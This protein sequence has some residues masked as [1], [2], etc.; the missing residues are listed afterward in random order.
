[1]THIHIPQ[2]EVICCYSIKVIILKRKIYFLVKKYWTQKNKC[3]KNIRY[4][5]SNW[6]ISITLSIKDDQ[7][8]KTLSD[9]IKLSTN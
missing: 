3:L 8:D 1:M 9:N 2:Y 4:L 7:Y 6:M 5:A